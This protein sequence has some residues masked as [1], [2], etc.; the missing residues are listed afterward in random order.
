MLTS[1]STK[2]AASSRPRFSLLSDSARL[3]RFAQALSWFDQG[4]V[5][6]T[7]FLCLLLVARW[8]DAAALGAFAFGMSVLAVLL[9]AQEALV[10][11]P[12]TIRLYRLDIPVAQQTSQAF[13]LSASLG[14]ASGASLLAAF[15]VSIWAGAPLQIQ[16]M[17]LALAFAGPCLLLREF[18]RKQAYAH[19]HIH[20]ALLVSAPACVLTVGVVMLLGWSG[21]LTAASAI[22]AIGLASAVSGLVWLVSNNA[23][24]GPRL[25]GA[26][27]R[28]WELGKWFLAAQTALQAQAYS[29]TWVTFVLGGASLAGVYAACASIVGLANPLLYGFFNLLLPQSS[30]AFHQDGSAA[31]R[32]KTV[33]SALQ[34]CAIMGVFCVALALC[35]EWLMRLL[36]PHEYQS[37]GR[38]LV[39]LALASWAG[40]VG[41]PASIALAAAERAGVVAVIVSATALLN[42]ALIIVLL[43][44]AGL[45][46]AAVAMLVAELAGSAARWVVFLV[47]MKSTSR[48]PT[49][50]AAAA[51][52]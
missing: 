34:L 51:G 43:P 24:R 47:L 29:T 49:L 23:V 2:D 38:I 15:A 20:D 41:A 17:L 45:L 25:A 30:R 6:A 1:S 7:S 48:T 46:G 14:G 12:Y 11:R 31:L 8:T 50:K 19:L 3:L 39:I 16:H 5:S 42:L 9:A 21:V 13:W 28:S 33:R 22:V 4:L 35:G 10:V 37:Q 52:G 32:R 40:T 27:R 36:Y 26:W 44:S 18:A